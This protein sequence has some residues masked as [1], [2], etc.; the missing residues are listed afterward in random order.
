MENELE[1]DFA[2]TASFNYA[3]KQ[4]PSYTQS[5]VTQCAKQQFHFAVN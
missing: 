5:Q 1:I 4:P 2:P 3:L